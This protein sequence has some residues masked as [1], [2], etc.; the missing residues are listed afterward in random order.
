MFE[1]IRARIFEIQ[2]VFVLPSSVVLFAL[3]CFCGCTELR[4]EKILRYRYLDTRFLRYLHRRCCFVS[5]VFCYYAAGVAFLKHSYFL[6]CA[7]F[8]SDFSIKLLLATFRFPFP[9]LL[10][11]VC[12]E[13]FKRGFR[14]GA[15]LWPMSRNVSQNESHIDI[16]GICSS[17]YS[18]H[19]LE[20]L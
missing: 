18:A 5:L 6:A 15:I 10:Y 16:G 13:C 8:L 1:R 9:P 12:A 3:V 2:F 19:S 20:K 17:L 11:F 4:F 14:T 7:L